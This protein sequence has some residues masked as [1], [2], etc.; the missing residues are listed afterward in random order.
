MELDSATT[1]FNVICHLEPAGGIVLTCKDTTGR[2]LSSCHWVIYE[3]KSNHVLGKLYRVGSARNLVDG[4]CMV[5]PLAFGKKYMIRVSKHFA[6]EEGGSLEYESGW[7]SLSK[8]RPVKKLKCVLKSDA[9]TRV[10]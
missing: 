7:F 4:T 3:K 9:R 5:E 10:E 8:S 1:N 6:E 2:P